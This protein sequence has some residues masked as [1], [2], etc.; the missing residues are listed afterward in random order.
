[1]NL[2]SHPVQTALGPTLALIFALATSVS[3]PLTTAN[4][5]TIVSVSGS[6]WCDSTSTCNNTNTS[7]LSNDF[8]GGNG[9]NLFHD[10]FSFNIPN[11]TIT[12]ATLSIM[13]NCTNC[14]GEPTDTYSLYGAAGISYSNLVSGPALSSVNV[15]IA[16][17]PPAHFVDFQLDVTAIALLNAAGGG[18]FL[19]GGGTDFTGSN[20]VSGIFGGDPGAQAQL[21]LNADAVPGPIAG[22]GLPGLIMAGAG[23]L[24]WCRR[25]RKAEAAA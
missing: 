5:S 24:G 14:A 13:N 23:L 9:A 20:T 22:A 1:M 19:F 6:G 12:S 17:T 11:I 16:D 7:V 2:N 15:G 10:W 18:N 4:A 3:I 25:K 21:I 8:A